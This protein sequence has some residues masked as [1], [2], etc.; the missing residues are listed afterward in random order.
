M[1]REECILAAGSK[2]CTDCGECLICDLDEDKECD[3]CMECLDMEGFK[4]VEVSGVDYDGEE[5]MNL[6]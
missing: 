3:N 4:A 5:G 2:P 6:Q 1:N